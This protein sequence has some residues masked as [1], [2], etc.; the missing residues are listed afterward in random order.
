MASLGHSKRNSTNL[1]AE[2]SKSLY[3]VR[4]ANLS[5]VLMILLSAIFCFVW[6]RGEQRISLDR[7]TE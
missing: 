7:E 6:E 2:L 5:C 1:T 3:V 4:I